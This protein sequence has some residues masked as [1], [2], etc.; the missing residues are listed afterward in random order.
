M[1]ITFRSS[2]YVTNN[3][4]SST[5]IIVNKPAGVAADDML[6]AF[7]AVRGDYTVSSAP[8]GWTLE[9]STF[10]VNDNTGIRH[11]CY[12]KKAGGSEST[13]YTW[14]HT[15]GGPFAATI[16]AYDGVSTST[17]AV[18]NAGSTRSTSATDTTVS[19]PAVDNLT[20]STAVALVCGYAVNPLSA[21]TV[22]VVFTPPSGMAERFDSNMEVGVSETLRASLGVADLL[23]G[24][25]TSASTARVATVSN[26]GTNVGI[27]LFLLAQTVAASGRAGVW[28]VLRASQ[29]VN[30]AAV[31]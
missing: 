31:I 24:L 4:T 21:S 22:N 7:V 28:G 1:A 5:Q 25:T 18:I 8:S 6:L 2:T 3:T 15:F 20:T 26:S 17:G 19:C 13:A 10:S 27:A 14:V 9:R 23:T 16:L 30:R 29:A 12:S 11:Y